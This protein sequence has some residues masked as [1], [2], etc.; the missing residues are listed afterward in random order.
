MI[1]PITKAQLGELYDAG[2]KWSEF[3]DKNTDASGS[4]IL[5]MSFTPKSYW[6]GESLHRS[7]GANWV[8]SS[9]GQL[10]NTFKHRDLA[11]VRLGNAKK[12][13]RFGALKTII[14][15]AKNAQLNKEYV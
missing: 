10:Y 3:N 12:T 4:F 6:P 9:D 15:W 11:P 7:L 2:V 8:L 13:D 5:R 14:S 1:H